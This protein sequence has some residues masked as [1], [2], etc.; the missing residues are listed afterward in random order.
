[1]RA[2]VMAAGTYTGAFEGR[3]RDEAVLKGHLVRMAKLMRSLVRMISDEHGGDLQMP[4]SRMF[5]DSASTLAYLLD[6]PD[7]PV[8]FDAYV[9]HSLSAEQN[10][11]REVYKNVEDRGGVWMPI[12]DRMVKSISRTFS[13]AGVEPKTLPH[14]RKAGWPSAYERLKLLG[15]AAYT[16][17]QMGSGSIHGAW[18]DIRSQTT[19][20]EDG[21]DI[22]FDADAVRPQP[23]LLMSLVTT[24][25]VRDYLQVCCADAL[26]DVEDLL[27]ELE[28]RG[29]W[30]DTAHERFVSVARMGREP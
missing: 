29:R 25:V 27:D 6:D 3:A 1:M 20:T 26:A 17:Y 5:L 15:P 24:T 12:E 30:I 22:R 8:R 14:H 4:I 16:A 21:Y 18:H 7:D 23:L 13:E 9:S 28:R 2:A 11:L 10:L 19:R